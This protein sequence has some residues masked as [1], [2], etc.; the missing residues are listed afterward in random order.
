MDPRL[1]DE[2]NL[3][4]AVGCVWGDW[5]VISVN[6]H[7]YVADSK[8]QSWKNS[9]ADNYMYE[10]YYWENIPARV[11]KEHDGMLYF[12]DSNGKLCVF[13]S[14][15]GGM[16]RFSDNGAAITAEWATKADDDGDF[17]RYKTLIR[18]G[19]G[20]MCKPYTNSS[21]KILI[22]TDRDFGVQIRSSSLS[23]FDFKEL[24]FS[25]FSFNTSDGPQITAFNR[26][27]R[28]YKTSRSSCGTTGSIRASGC[29]GL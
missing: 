6:S 22:R 3:S 28:K 26:K 17:M 21:V 23:I 25:N 15:R 18:R 5:Y 1:T 29:L 13:N 24:D 10:W 4:D 27:I 11:L 2:N 19:S 14:D 8:Q 20:V 9:V 16:N 12:G 7:C